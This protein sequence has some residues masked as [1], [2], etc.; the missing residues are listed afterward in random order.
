MRPPPHLYRI[1]LAL[2]L[3]GCAAA[4]PLWTGGSTTPRRRGDLA[5]GGAARIVTSGLQVERDEDEPG[6]LDRGETEAAEFLQG[7]VIPVARARYGIS[8]HFD[9]GLG[10]S[11]TGA[12]LELRH[13][14]GVIEDTTR[15][16]W[17]GT[18]ALFG[19][20]LVRDRDEMRLRGARFGLEVPVAYGTDFGGIYDVW[21]GAVV[22]AEGQLGPLGPDRANG[23]AWGVRAGGFFGIGAGFRRVHAFLEL[24]ADFE[25]W[26]VGFDGIETQLKTGLALTPSFGIR[27]R[28]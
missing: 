23:S 3:T 12:R 18:L 21:L 1:A 5:F 20:A 24:R 9:L 15:P 6:E 19:G 16:A 4:E 14:W 27:I 10:A 7:G 8:R 11:G 28:I 25:A 26:W 22:G 17:V 13:E 2:L